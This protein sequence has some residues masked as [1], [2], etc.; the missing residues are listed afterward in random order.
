MTHESNYFFEK[1]HIFYI[2]MLFSTF[3][4]KKQFYRFQNDQNDRLFSAPIQRS[5]CNCEQTPKKQDTATQRKLQRNFIYS[6]QGAICPISMRTLWKPICCSHLL[7][8]VCKSAF[9][10][11]S[12]F[13]V[14]CAITLCICKY[15]V[16]VQFKK[17]IWIKNDNFH[18]YTHIIL[19]INSKLYELEVKFQ[20]IE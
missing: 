19:R 9:I 17:G 16:S 7:I 4:R 14:L 10:C 5:I 12:N 8:L 13:S 6:E 1:L 20:C 11:D 3:V 15:I 2:E 18:Q